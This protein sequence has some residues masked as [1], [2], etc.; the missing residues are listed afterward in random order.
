MKA[1]GESYIPNASQLHLDHVP[2]ARFFRFTAL[3]LA[4]AVLLVTFVELQLIDERNS[5]ELSKTT[6]PTDVCHII[7][8]NPTAK[9][10]WQFSTRSLC[11]SASVCFNAS[12]P[13]GALYHTSDLSATRC[14]VNNPDFSPTGITLP[15]VINGT[16]QTCSQ[17]QHGFVHCAHGPGLLRA[18]PVCP[19]VK[20][21]SPTIRDSA[22]WHEDVSI[23]VPD[24]AYTRNIYHFVNPITDVAR[25]VDHLEILLHRWE[26]YNARGP[27]VHPTFAS[28]EARLRK[29]NIMFQG[30]RAIP[31]SHRWKRELLLLLIRERM[32]KK[33]IKVT[34][35][36]LQDDGTETAGFKC[37]RSA[38]IL[39][40]RGHFDVWPF[41]NTTKVPLDGLSVP[42]DAITFKKDVFQGL[43]IKNRLPAT[44]SEQHGHWMFEL[45]PLTVAYAKREG[46]PDPDGHYKAGAMRTFFEDDEAWFIKMLRNESEE[47]GA[48]FLTIMADSSQSLKTQVEAVIRVGFI[49]GIHGANLVN[50]IFMHP[51][52]ALME[53]LP[54]FV[55]HKCY[56]AGAN[57]GLKYLSFESSEQ[58]GV[59]ESGCYFRDA[60]CKTDPR[61]RRVKLG[62]RDDRRRV[63]EL[64]RAG[65][66]HLRQLHERFPNG[67]PVKFNAESQYYEVDEGR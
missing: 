49:V 37:L 66:Q 65:I 35:H 56:V 33:G 34:V 26:R 6:H 57:S 17:F 30:S 40:R 54:K 53:V 62:R 10:L 64:L 41:P 22:T 32:I 48:K 19:A 58:A 51:F 16:W 38:V 60:Y 9:D 61:Q 47:A 15:N 7:G 11:L 18:T 13:S 29:I 2:K 4:A 55:Q 24:Y 59:V 42:L 20:E 23:L 63:R 1:N 8:I 12:N 3:F 46:I 28:G 50:A 36:F 45:P 44:S 14:E 21:S 27:G 43:G 39:G 25:T 5:I 52:G 67:I 31:L